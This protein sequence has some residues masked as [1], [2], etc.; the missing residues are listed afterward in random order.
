MKIKIILTLVAIPF[1]VTI[2]DD[3]T[4]PLYQDQA[5]APAADSTSHQGSV[6]T[7]SIA[8]P[9]PRPDSQ[10]LSQ[11]IVQTDSIMGDSSRPIITNRNDS[12]LTSI[13]QIPVDTTR[14][15]GRP[16][17]RLLREGGSGSSYNRAN[18]EKATFF[19]CAGKYSIRANAERHLE[20]L[21]KMGYS[22]KLK[23][24]GQKE[25]WVVLKKVKG[26]SRAEKIKTQFEK[27][28]LTCFIEEE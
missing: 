20:A 17:G 1:F 9:A 11:R 19:V 21:Q 12:T 10:P 16:N 23:Y 8:N 4:K 5:Q 27:D 3:Q 28:G 15:D 18:R 6:A 7:D 13:S 2:A 22:P 25:Y 24:D 26:I 14:P